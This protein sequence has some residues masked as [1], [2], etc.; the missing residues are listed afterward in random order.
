MKSDLND[1]IISHLINFSNKIT[2]G[3]KNPTVYF[4][5]IKMAKIHTVP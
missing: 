3:N 2:D 1:I 5:Q 4:G